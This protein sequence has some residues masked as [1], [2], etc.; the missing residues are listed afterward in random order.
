MSFIISS[1]T[2]LSALF[3]KLFQWTIGITLRLKCWNEEQYMRQDC[4]TWLL[5][6]TTIHNF[7][8]T[9]YSHLNCFIN[10][11]ELFNSAQETSSHFTDEKN[12]W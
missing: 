6:S 8:A 9:I 1:A 12:E 11:K 10:I 2:Y 4:H 3:H 5:T 7:I